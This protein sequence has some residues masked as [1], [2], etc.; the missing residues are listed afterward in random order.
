MYIIFIRSQYLENIHTSCEFFFLL[1]D[2]SN[3]SKE[4]WHDS[5]GEPIQ[6]DNFLSLGC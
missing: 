6:S 1:Y 2:Y 3:T 4:K 5:N